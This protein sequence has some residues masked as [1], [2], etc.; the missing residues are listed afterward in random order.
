MEAKE[1]RIGNIIF[2]GRVVSL[3]DGD[4]IVNDGYQD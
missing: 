4:I 2:N 1:L 3:P